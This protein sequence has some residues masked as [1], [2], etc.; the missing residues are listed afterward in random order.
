VRAKGVYAM[1]SRHLLDYA[2]MLDNHGLYE[3]ADMLVRQAAAMLKEDITSEEF[4]EALEEAVLAHERS[5]Q[6]IN[7]RA[8]EVEPSVSLDK[9]PHPI[10]EGVDLTS[11]PRAWETLSLDPDEPLQ[12]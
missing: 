1:T 12:F 3:E 11:A 8:E 6:A 9:S 2:E 5:G 7:M 10:F 4:A